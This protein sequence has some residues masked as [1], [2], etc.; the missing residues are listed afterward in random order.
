MNTLSRTLSKSL[1]ALYFL[2][3]F[4]LILAGCAKPQ[5]VRDTEEPRLDDH[6]MSLRFDREDLDRLYEDN[7][8][9]LLNSRVVRTWDRGDNP[10]V[11]IFPF[12]NETSE[13]IDSQLD[14]LLSKFETDLVN[15][16]A[17]DVISHSD[18]EE[19]IDEVRRQQA[20][21]YNPQEIAQYGRQMGA[22]YFVTGRVYDV[23]ERIDDERRVQYFLF[24]QVIEVE[25]SK[26][27]YQHE[28][29][30]TKGLVR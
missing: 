13:H 17:V 26:I 20:E 28:T 29:K 22:Q 18:Q 30:L 4:G 5:Y 2:A 3:A 19:L 27:H 11:A 10:N 7:I 9:E 25:T 1:V 6:T 16:T 23:S 15:R 14:T 8:H 12:R 24:V 21:E